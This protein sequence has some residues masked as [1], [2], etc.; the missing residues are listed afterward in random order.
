MAQEEKAPRNAEQFALEFPFEPSFAREEF[1]TAPSNAD[2]LAM[3]DRWPSWPDRLLLLL[4]PAGSGKSHLAAA[5]ATRARALVASPEALPLLEV[6][7]RL[8]PEA[9]VVDGLEQIRDETALFH[10]LNYANE[11]NIHILLTGRLRPREDWVR[12]PDLL[13]RL[14]RAPSIE[15]GAPDEELIRAVLEKL[16][17]DRQ[18]IVEPG[19]ADYLTLRL[20]RS[21]E[22]ARA[23]VRDLDRE[24]LMRGRRLTRV[25]AGELLDRAREG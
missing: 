10:L 25:L 9:I 23:F 11:N 22:A 18:L 12:L 4:G 15:I 21:L 14:R 16:F 24:A 3:I 13:S 8:K 17:R 20:E 6:L 5:W 19:L 1:L 7:A 2:A